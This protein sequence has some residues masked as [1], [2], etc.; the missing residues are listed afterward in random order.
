MSARKTFPHPLCKVHC[1]SGLTG[2]ETSGEVRGINN[3]CSEKSA[4]E[5]RCK[6]GC[7]DIDKDTGDELCSIEDCCGE[8]N[9]SKECG[10]GDGDDLNPRIATVRRGRARSIATT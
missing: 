2:E 9:S 6:G 5:E 8:K 10:K 1:A 7:G 3:H 4:A